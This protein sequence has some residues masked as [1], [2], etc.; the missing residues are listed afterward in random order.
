MDRD[1]AS[2]QHQKAAYMAKAISAP[3][4]KLMTLRVPHIS[5]SPMLISE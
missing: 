4:A 1:L 3:W 2:D 5:V